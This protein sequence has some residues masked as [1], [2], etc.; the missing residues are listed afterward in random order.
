MIYCILE[1]CQEGSQLINWIAHHKLY[2]LF[3]CH[4]RDNGGRGYPLKASLEWCL[5]EEHRIYLTRFYLN[6]N[7]G[8]AGP[9]FYANVLRRSVRLLFGESYFQ[10]FCFIKQNK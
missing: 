9:R 4:R 6:S 7:N 8:R 5:L 2:R 3:F 1:L 10:N